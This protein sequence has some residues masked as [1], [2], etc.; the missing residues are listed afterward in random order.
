VSEVAKGD[1]VAFLNDLPSSRQLPLQSARAAINSAIFPDDV[2]D[3][4][5]AT[6]S[7]VPAGMTILKFGSRAIVG[8]YP[9]HGE[10]VVLKYYEPAS[11]MKHLTYGILGSRCYRSWV[12]GLTFGFLGVPTP[13]PLM[14]AEWK[15]LGGLWLSRSFLATRHAAGKPLAEFAAGLPSDDP[16]LAKVAESLRSA[17]SI[18]AAHRAVHGDLKENNIIVAPDG[19]ISFIDLDA[20]SFLLPEKEW[21]QLWDRDRRRFLKNWK[22][23]PH[24]E[25]VFRNVFNDS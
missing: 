4:L 6:A 2:P 24:L 9:I 14:I 5:R 18:M 3:K 20:T 17:F 21:K 8:S 23:A 25:A 10:P 19:S 13:A 15:A 7:R 22:S 1:L 16:L 12:A 11:F